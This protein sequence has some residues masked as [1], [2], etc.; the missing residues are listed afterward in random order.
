MVLINAYTGVNQ[1][2]SNLLME[3]YDKEEVEKELWCDKEEDEK[4]K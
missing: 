4:E 1:H 3:Y 2:F